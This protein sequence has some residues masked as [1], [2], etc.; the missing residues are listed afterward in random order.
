MPSRETRAMERPMLIPILWIASISDFAEWFGEIHRRKRY[1]GMKSRKGIPRIMRRMSLI[2]IRISGIRRKEYRRQKRM[3]TG[4][5]IVIVLMFFYQIP[6]MVITL[7][8]MIM[9]KIIR[10]L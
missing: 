7:C 9:I 5:F 10:R 1:P 8:T 2:S 3:S 6:R 4:Y